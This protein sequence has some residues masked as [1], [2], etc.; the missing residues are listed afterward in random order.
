MTRTH[1]V[2]FL[3]DCEK[4]R[5]G[6][7]PP[8][9]NLPPMN[10]SRGAKFRTKD[11]K[12]LPQT[13]PLPLLA[14]VSGQEATHAVYTFNGRHRVQEVG[15]R[16]VR[17]SE[18]EVKHLQ[19]HFPG[20]I[21]QLPYEDEDEGTIGRLV[22][23]KRKVEKEAEQIAADHAAAAEEL[24]KAQRE[25]EKQ[26]TARAALEKEL[27]ALKDAAS[28]ER[29]APKKKSKVSASLDVTKDG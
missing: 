22:E 19:Y 29:A 10:D 14:S 3:R 11:G 23:E 18:D 4:N 21:E 13:I 8:Y 9:A 6:G 26:R 17:L 27:E 2:M 1:R 12:I 20:L 24:E 15:E 25:L 28:R 16:I 5:M 7:P